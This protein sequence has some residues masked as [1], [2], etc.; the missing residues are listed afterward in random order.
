MKIAI[1]EDR[2]ILT[3]DRDYG[4]FIFKHN[5]KPR[6]G[7]IYLRFEEYTPEEPGIIVENILKNT[8]IDLQRTLTVVDK[9]GIRQRKY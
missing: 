3:F 5:Y 2:T 7:V 9:F 8:N 6:K 1:S 4:E